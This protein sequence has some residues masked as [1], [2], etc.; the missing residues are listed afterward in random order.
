MVVR[1]I[2]NESELLSKIAEGDHRAFSII[3]EK[4]QQLI[5]NIA[6]R[7]T[8][9]RSHAKEIVQD[10]FLKIWNRRTDLNEIE[11]FGAYLNRIARNQ[12]IDGLRVI[13][14]E[15][16]RTVELQ[17][18]HLERGELQTEN[19]VEYKETA[20][21][22]QQALNSLPVQQRR[23]YQLCHEQGM[24]YEEAAIAMGIS[25]GTVQTHM[26]VALRNMRKYLKHLDTLLVLLY[27][28]SK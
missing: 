14:R 3:F 20:D 17:E 15:A 5:F 8:R 9:S 6:Y 13:A 28:T 27:L 22:I 1:S 18:E 2:F 12:C 19:A 4:H 25:P 11:N 7:I 26:K 23:V 21:L 10:V 16:L 24:K